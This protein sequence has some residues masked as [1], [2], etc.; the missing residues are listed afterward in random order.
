MTPNM[1]LL[2]DIPG[3]SDRSVALRV[4]PQAERAIRAGHPWL[5]A[6]AIRRQSHN[7][8]S[9]DLAVIF[10]RK[11]RFLAV[12]LYD[13]TSQIRVRLLQIGKSAPINQD[14]FS[15]RLALAADRRQSLPAESTTGYRLVHGENDGLPGLIIDRYDKDYVLKLYTTAWVPHLQPILAALLAATAGGRFI[16]RLARHVQREGDALY[17]LIDGAT[18]VGPPPDGPSPFLENGLRFEADL[19][20]GQKTGFFLDQRENRARVEPLAG[21]KSV[22]NVFAY[23]GGFSLYAARGGALDVVSLDMSRPALDAAV[24]HFELNRHLPSVAA[25]RHETLQGDAF[26]LLGQLAEQ[27]R[28][29]DM[30]ILDPPTF[31]RRQSEVAKALA[32]YGRL[33]RLGLGLLQRNGILVAASC[34]SRVPAPDFFNVV[35]R[36]AVQQGRLLQEIERTGHALDHPISFKEGAYLKCLFAKVA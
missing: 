10:D 19:I 2:S 9:G 4:T 23:T 18:L 21:G 32:A 31:A 30:V 14:W 24:R 15:N 29:F 36:A 16:L 11:G 26:A 25:A 13:P 33:A 22:L 8:R 1:T 3:P 27:D 20:R 17:G 34:S 7:G 5:F 6:G 12:G 28:R 35:N